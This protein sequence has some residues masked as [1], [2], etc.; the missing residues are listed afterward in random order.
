MPP[1]QPKFRRIDRSTARTFFVMPPDDTKSTPVA[2]MARTVSRLT[3][4][5]A[6]SATGRPR[7]RLQGHRCREILEAEV[8]EQHDVGSGAQRLFQ[9]GERLDFHLHLDASGDGTGGSDCGGDR[10]RGGDVVLFDEHHVVKTHAVI[11]AAAAPHGILLRRAQ[12]REG[13]AG[14]EDRAA[15]AGDRGGEAARLGGGR[16][17]ELQEVERSALAG[18]D[19][20][21]RALDL[22]DHRSGREPLP[23]RRPPGEADA[24]VQ[25]AKS[26]LGPGAATEHRVLTGDDPARHPL[27]LGDELCRD[28]A[29]TDVLPQRGSHLL[30]QVRR[31]GE[32]G[33]G[34]LARS[35]AWL[36]ASMG[37]V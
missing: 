35:R 34:R 4:P 5:E 20:P 18:E 14:V 30:R 12:A 31:R 22:E 32:V 17:E 11:A 25:A 33:R 7:E 13:L 19:R 9:L 36:K 10:A 29:A 28:V 16:G 2:A 15:G 1:D 24:R 21:G 27:V 23:V 6:S 8:I 3:L 26:L 37:G